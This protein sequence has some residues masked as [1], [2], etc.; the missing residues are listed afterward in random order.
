[1]YI[2]YKV[3]MVTVLAW[4]PS[5][6]IYMIY[7]TSEVPTQLDSIQPNFFYCGT[8]ER[9]SSLKAAWNRGYSSANT[10]HTTYTRHIH[11]KA[12]LRPTNSVWK[13]LR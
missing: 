13:T 1:M 6:M 10:I 5:Y 3:P 9:L 2:Q 7:N 4:Q 12:E 8:Y 11:K